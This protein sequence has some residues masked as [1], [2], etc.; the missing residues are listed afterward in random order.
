MNNVSEV[1]RETCFSEKLKEISICGEMVL[2]KLM[3]LKVDK[4]P[5]PNNLHPRILKEVAL[6]ILDPLVAMVQNSLDPGLVPTD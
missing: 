4:F 1:L 2:G 6:E 3:G 5:G